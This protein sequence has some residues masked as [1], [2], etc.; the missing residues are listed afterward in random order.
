MSAPAKTPA[1]ASSPGPNAHEVARIFA[2]HLLALYFPL[3]GTLFLATGPH[4]WWQALLF[5]IPLFVAHVL[6]TRGGVERRRPHP[7]LPAWPFDALVYALAGLQL[8]NIALLARMFSQASLFSVD[9]LM[10]LVVVGS[11]SGFSIITA[12][13]LIHRCG[14]FDRLLGRALLG[15]VL[16]EHFF[17]E[18]LRGH[19]V[20][21]G[22]PEDPATA[23]FGETFHQFY[24]RTV[25]AQFR[26][27]WRLEARRLGDE[28]MGLLDRRIL[29][30]RVLHGLVL[31]WG[32]ALAILAAAGGVA[33][34][35][36]LLQAFTATRLLEV[37]NYF[38]HWGLVRT[39]RRVE[40]SDSWDT[41]SWFTYY[42]LVG[43]SRHA[44]HHAHASRPYQQLR[45]WEEPPL[46]PHGYIG[47]IF[48][49]LAKNWRFRAYATEEL[50]RRK[51]G[52][53]AESET[54]RASAA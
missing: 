3:T 10:A 8:L 33:F 15:T 48:M 42:A 47:T 44:D 20:R 39:G 7:A 24:R 16:Y 12:H 49:V 11:A 21:V 30:S 43:L 23:R 31:E 50:R 22:T 40:P 25:P 36:F 38:E 18:H 19:H 29:G 46:L 32:L 45:V 51:L 13:E 28:N 14:R 53:F 54:P 5:L 27:A 34:V 26:S 41:H 1:P 4:P 9:V 17:T 6:D 35:A 52:P 37:V 2:P